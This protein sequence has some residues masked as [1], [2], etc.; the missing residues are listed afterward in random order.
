MRVDL[1]LFAAVRDIVGTDRLELE[2][3]AGST[4]ADVWRILIRDHPGLGAHRIPMVAINEAYADPRQ[5]LQ[6]ND[7]LA[8]IPPVSGG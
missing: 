8:F 2:L 7:E 6:D 5:T 1:L 3:P 4:A